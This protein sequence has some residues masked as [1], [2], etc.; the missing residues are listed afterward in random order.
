MAQRQS[1]LSFSVS[2]IYSLIFV[3]PKHTISRSFHWAPHTTNAFSTQNRLL[4]GVAVCLCPTRHLASRSFSS[5]SPFSFSAP[6][7]HI[8]VILLLLLFLFLFLCHSH[9]PFI[10][11]FPSF[12]S[13]RAA[14]V[15]TIIMLKFAKLL[16]YFFYNKL[17]YFIL[18]KN[19]KHYGNVGLFYLL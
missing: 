11:I 4:A 17:V 12:K 15:L 18:V 6:Y 3:I 10:L 2:N 16:F 7:S 19:S 9:H 14:H 8:F 1:C 5:L 13:S